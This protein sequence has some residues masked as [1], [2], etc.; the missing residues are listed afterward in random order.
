MP[1]GGRH[2]LE[3]HANE[4]MTCESRGPEHGNDTRNLVYNNPNL[5]KCYF[6]HVCVE[7]PDQHV[8]TLDHLNNSHAHDPTKTPISRIRESVQKQDHSK[9]STE[10][11]T[12]KPAHEWDATKP[13]REGAT[14]HPAHEWYS[15]DHALK[16][17]IQPADDQPVPISIAQAIQPLSVLDNKLD[18][19]VAN[20][21]AQYKAA[22]S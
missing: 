15:A 14:P 13:T 8:E 5:G 10:R 21:L 11:A 6:E 3:K 20:L 22:S 19:L 2:K 7:S 4:P 1:D 9:P 18:D 16:P 17:V 12:T